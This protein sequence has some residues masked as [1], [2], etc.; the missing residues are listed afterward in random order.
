MKG[1]TSKKLSEENAVDFTDTHHF[2]DLTHV[3]NE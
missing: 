2:I 3:M 1:F